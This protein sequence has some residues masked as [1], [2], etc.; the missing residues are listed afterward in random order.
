MKEYQVKGMS[1]A[2]CQTRVEKAVK[3]LPG[4]DSVQVSLLTN[5][6][7]VQGDISEKEIEKAVKNAGYRAKAV[8]TGKGNERESK[9]DN[10]ETKRMILRLIASLT[11]LLPLMYLS[12]GHMMWN[13]PLPKGLAMNHV[14][15]GVAELLLTL[16]VLIINQKFFVNGFSGLIHRSPNM[17]TLVAMGSFASLSYSVYVLYEM[18]RASKLGNQE[19]VME[20]MH[21]FYFESAAMIVSLITVGKVLESFSKGKTTSALKGLMQLKVP[22]ATMIEIQ[23][24]GSH[25][26]KIVDVEE[27][28]VGTLFAVKPGET[29]P[30]DGVVLEGTSAVNE[31]SLTGESVPV[32]KKVGDEVSSVTINQSGYLICKASRVG[33]DTTIAQIIKL[34]R[35][36]STSKAP[37]A[38]V[39]DKVSGIFVPVVMGISLI[40]IF[41]WLIAGET[42][43]FAL[44]R[45]ISVLVISCPC[46]LGLATPVAIMVGSGVGARNGILF[47]NATALEN[48]GKIKSI[49]FDKTGTMTEGKTEVTDMFCENLA[50]LLEVAYSL[51][52]KSE[53]PL[54]KAIV[55]Y[56]KLQGIK[57]KPIENFEVVV[58]NGLKATM[59][60]S[61]IY[62]GSKKY[63]D[64][65][66]L[67]PCDE[68]MELAEKYSKQGKTT[69]FFAKDNRTIGMLAV[70]DRLKGDSK[71]AVRQLQ[72][73]DIQ[74]TM[75]TGDN[76][77]VAEYIG[78]EAGVKNVVAEVLPQE[79][80]ERIRELSKEGMVAMVGDGIN[81]APALTRADIGIAIGAGTDVAMDAADI[82]LVKSSLSDVPAAIRLSRG[83]LK[84]IHENLF[85]AFI[86]N[87][88]GIP[89]AAGGW[90]PL[91]GLKLSPMFAAAAM[92][93]SSV[94]V[95]TNALRLNL[96][97]IKR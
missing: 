49:A 71:I 40:T 73:M 80:E 46:A 58:G 14:A 82:V 76:Q 42:V 33:E 1:C 83:V 92:S 4:V 63:M 24:D 50:N 2:V 88:I 86:Y 54:A 64:S 17:D 39:A 9:L 60:G 6:M 97:K 18:I 25:V 67:K 89:L 35:E 74:V 28:K 94:C 11:L 29:I 51:E 38:K 61:V 21:D 47:K 96:L 52:D 19:L 55:N 93:L 48:A 56:A 7:Q 53:H 57:K 77:Q 10:Q 27:I 91:F 30:V 41:G 20:Y 16:G 90:Y 75:L 43:G 87:I 79:K 72:D 37:I 34:V 23:S 95:V 36:A 69:L 26:E 3:D 8:K 31:S 65:L 22:T 59:D 12:M 70:A 44:A 5:S 62:G 45:G 66:S 13:W 84:N 85:W 15:I 81:D 78:K 68:C 32:D